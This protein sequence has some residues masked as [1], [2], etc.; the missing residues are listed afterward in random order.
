MRRT[1]LFMIIWV[2]LVPRME[3]LAAEFTKTGTA[4]AQFLEIGIDSRAIAMGEAFVAVTDGASSIYW[5]PAGLTKLEKGDLSFTHVEWLADINYDFVSFGIPLGKLGIGGVSVSLLSMGEMEVTTLEDPEGI[6]GRTFNASDLCM[7]LSYA[8]HLTD[9]FAIGGNVK[10]VR[11]SVWN[12]VANDVA[13]DIGTLYY[14][15]FKSLRIGMCMSNFGP[16]MTFSGRDLEVEYERERGDPIPANLKTDSYPLPLNFRVGVAYD[17]VDSNNQLL[18]V[19]LDAN[20]PNDNVERLNL[21]LEYWY[22]RK[23]AA[24]VGYKFNYDEEGLTAGGGCKF[25]VG[26]AEVKFDYAYANFGAL[27]DVHRVSMGVG[28]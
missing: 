25:G 13:F 23:F 6:S 12:E 7:G 4:G 10:Y 27:S 17:I 9:K 16:E 1:L 11:Q 14:T 3:A 22:M 24:R 18:T 20:H 15:G 19:A 2:V 26:A 28:F 8:K 5:N 21:G